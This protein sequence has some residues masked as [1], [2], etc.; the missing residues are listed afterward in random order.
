MHYILMHY[1]DALC[2]N[3]L[4][5]DTLYSAALYPDALH[6]D[7]HLDAHLSVHPTAYSDAFHS[8]AYSDDIPKVNTLMP[9]AHWCKHWWHDTA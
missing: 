5:P 8:D 3:A 1:T 7:A 9:H 4:Y 6:S 2:S